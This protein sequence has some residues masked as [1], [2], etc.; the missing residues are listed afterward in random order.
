MLRRQQ[1][2]HLLKAFPR[3]IGVINSRL[4]TGPL[5][6]E[7]DNIPKKNAAGRNIMQTYGWKYLATWFS[8]YLPCLI[9]FFYALDSDSLHASDYGLDPH[10]FIVRICEYLE[11]VSSKEH[12]LDGIKENP[13]F[14]TFA[15]AYLMADLVPTTI[16]AAALLK[17]S[18]QKSDNK[19][20][21]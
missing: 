18:S 20:L 10:T 11:K 9:T 7:P 14:T 1:A 13:R 2:C 17:F 8:V 3:T 19:V 15:A 12:L 5:N 16:I 6:Q 21:R 4:F